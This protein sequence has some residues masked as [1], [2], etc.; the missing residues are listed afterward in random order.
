MITLDENNT[1]LI[2]T[3]QD[4]E[5]LLGKWRKQQK[6]VTQVKVEKIGNRK[7]FLAEIENLDGTKAWQQVDMAMSER[8]SKC[9]ID[10]Y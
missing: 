4:L 8:C 9:F 3:E 10:H 7:V 6:D 1:L 2:N 5:N